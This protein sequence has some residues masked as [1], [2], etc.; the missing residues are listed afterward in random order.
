MYQRIIAHNYCDA[1]ITLLNNRSLSSIFI[2]DTKEKSGI[3][4]KLIERLSQEQEN[5]YRVICMDH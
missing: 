2:T 1:W 5:C 3:R 4:I